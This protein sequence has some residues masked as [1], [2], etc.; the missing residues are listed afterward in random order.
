M[1]LKVTFIFIF[2]APTARIALVLLGLLLG[3]GLP[4]LPQER[5][6]FITYN[7]QMEEPGS[8][9]I[10]LNPVF[11]RQTGGHDFLAGWAE[12]EYG[13][14]GWWTAEFYLDGQSTRKD[15]TVFT[16]YR[17]ENRFRLLLHE[18][19]I[20]PVLYLELENIRGTDKTLLEV[21]GHDI[22]SDHATPNR[23]AGLEQKHEIESKLILSSN[24]NGW[25]VSENF[26]AE[27]NVSNQPWEFG[28]AVGAS[29]PLALAARP[30]PCTFCAENFA[31]GVEIYGGLGTSHAFGLTETSHYIAPLLSWSLPNG[32]TLRLSPS[33]GLNGNSHR[34]LLRWG[35]SFEIPGFGRRLRH[36]FR[37]KEE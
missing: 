35:V 3:S 37:G 15:S 28:Y 11:G 32:A 18:H 31:A 21:V 19:R 36:G 24:I 29:R 33:F 22:A 7:H 17:L 6:Y 34:L 20:N 8:L 14:K 12:F 26:I 1:K 10:A 9:E 30:D 13:V 16:G 27:K 23:E 5:P 4:A 25:N 2:E